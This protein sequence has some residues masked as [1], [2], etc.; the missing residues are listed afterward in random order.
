MTNTASPELER[1]QRLDELLEEWKHRFLKTVEEGTDPGVAR[2]V[3]DAYAE[4]FKK[5]IG[6]LAELNEQL[7]P[8]DFDPEALAE[9]RDI[10]IRWLVHLE[11]FDP[12]HPLN[13]IDYFLVKAE[14]IRHLVRDALD[15]H[16]DGADGDAE[17][18]VRNL[19]AWLPET[20]QST[21]ADLV[22]ISPR[23]FQRWKKDGGKPT[24]RLRLVAR[25]VA[26]LRRGWT[27]EGVV[28]WF[29]RPRRE[30]NGKRPI[31]VLDDP[32][33]ERPLGVAVRQGRAQ[34]GS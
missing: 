29:Y 6:R 7:H 18:V 31:E 3:D 11:D 22:G 12:E 27:E 16:V 1:L 23:Q 10:I 28:A 15:A 33:Y 5:T 20:S 32:D 30:L 21:L 24:R 2:E 4:R 26:I 9:I 34:H 8:E 19:Q 17:A 13:E 25:M 14:A